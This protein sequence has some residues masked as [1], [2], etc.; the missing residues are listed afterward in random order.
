MKYFLMLIAP[1]ILVGCGSTNTDS[2]DQLTNI[3]AQIRTAVGKNNDQEI[4]PEDRKKVTKLEISGLLDLKKFDT[5]AYPNLVE[6]TFACEQQDLSSIAE[7]KKLRILSV[8]GLNSR[9]DL[10]F[11]NNFPSSY[12][13]FF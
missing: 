10:S 12:F 6:L 5:A 8:F 11:L 9:S 3:E 4:T 2:N 7:L 13:Y 1:V